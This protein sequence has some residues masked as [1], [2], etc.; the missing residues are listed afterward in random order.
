ML[1]M[2]LLRRPLLHLKGKHAPSTMPLHVCGRIPEALYRV[3]FA[4]ICESKFRCTENDRNVTFDENGAFANLLTN[5]RHFENVLNE[6][7]FPGD[8]ALAGVE[9][10]SVINQSTKHG[11]ISRDFGRDVLVLGR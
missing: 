6:L 8:R 7:L 2:P 1:L 5:H 9:R 10:K 11:F 4:G 3:F